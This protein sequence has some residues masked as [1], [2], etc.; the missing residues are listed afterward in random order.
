MT[1]WTR[2]I[3]DAIGGIDFVVPE[4]LL[5]APRKEG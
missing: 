1:N 2:F 4:Q 5:A 3:R